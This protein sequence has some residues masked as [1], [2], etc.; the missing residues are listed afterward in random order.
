M[1]VKCSREVP[2]PQDSV[3]AELVKSVASWLRPLIREGRSQGRLLW[4]EMGPILGSFANLRLDL[5]R[6][7]TYRDTVSIPFHLRVEDVELWLSFDS[8]LTATWF[9]ASRTQ[10]ILESSYSQPTWMDGSEH[11]LLHRLVECVIRQF[12]AGVAAELSEQLH[13]SP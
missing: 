6:T 7:L 12:L 8:V 2:F 4:A 13:R 9:G 10:L 1:L 3:Q 11:L 5:G